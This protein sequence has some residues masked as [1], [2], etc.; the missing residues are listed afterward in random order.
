[1]TRDDII[2]AAFAAACARTQMLV[3]WRARFAAERVAAIRAA[4]IAARS[5]A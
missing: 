3:E 5:K 1:M 4:L 2:R